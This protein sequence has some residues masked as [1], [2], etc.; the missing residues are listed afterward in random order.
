VITAHPVL[1][2]FI[3]TVNSTTVTLY[4]DGVVVGTGTLSGGA[5]GSWATAG[6]LAIGLDTG[7]GSGTLNTSMGECGVATGYSDATAVAALD[8][9]LAAK[10]G[11]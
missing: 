10:W 11:L 9:Y 1:H 7:D 6:R 4:V 8:S 5:I 2:R 3:A